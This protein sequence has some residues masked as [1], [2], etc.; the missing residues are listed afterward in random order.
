MTKHLI[1]VNAHNLDGHFRRCLPI[2]P[3]THEPCNSLNDLILRI[4]EPDISAANRVK[5]HFVDV[6]EYCQGRLDANRGHFLIAVG[7]VGGGRRLLN[8]LVTNR[9]SNQ[10]RNISQSA[11]CRFG[12]NK[13]GWLV[14]FD[15]IAEKF[16]LAL[17]ELAESELRLWRDW[18]DLF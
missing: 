9:L 1:L 15:L 7:P 6:G 4:E 3:L 17:L 11:G 13:F 2:F 5:A 18:R 8:F 12:L 16:A 14:C 10:V